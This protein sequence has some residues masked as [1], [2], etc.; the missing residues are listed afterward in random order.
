MLARFAHKRM[1]LLLI[2]GGLA[3]GSLLGI[4]CAVTQLGASPADLTRARGQAESGAN[5]FAGA[6]VSCHGQRGEGLGG[7]S[8]I[9]GPDALPEY[10]SNTINAADPAQ[11]DPQLLQIEMQSRPAG[12]AWRDPFRNAQDLYNFISTHMPKGHADNLKVPERWAVVSFMLSVQGAT[13]PPGGI[14]PT[15]ASAIKIPR[16]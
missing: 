3:L 5:I 2:G 12:A 16:R 15:N 9:L 4:G 7:A 14:G 6:C 10:P 1:A 11:S 13:L 8:A